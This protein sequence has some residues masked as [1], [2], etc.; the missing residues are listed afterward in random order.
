MRIGI[1]LIGFRVTFG[2]IATLGAPPLLAIVGIV[3]VT[4]GSGVLAARWLG[5]GSVFGTLGGGAVAICGASAALSIATTL[6]PRR[7]SQAQLTLVLVGISATSAFAMVAYPV[8]AR[9]LHLSGAQAGFS[10][11]ASMHDVAQSLGAGF[12]Y[13]QASGEVATVVKLARVALLTPVLA[14]LPRCSVRPS[15]EGGRPCCLGSWSGSSCWP[16]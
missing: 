8:L 5:L 9:A 4:L 1:V 15:R 7:A 3:A 13:S 11:G 12:S 10:L 14:V 6:G 2:Q 16:E